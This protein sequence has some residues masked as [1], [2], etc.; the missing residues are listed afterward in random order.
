MRAVESI[1]YS[2]WRVYGSEAKLMCGRC[3]RD[4]RRPGVDVIRRGRKLFAR[5]RSPL[6]DAME[7]L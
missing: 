7:A 4:G 1:S 5:C 3:E 2:F 6:C